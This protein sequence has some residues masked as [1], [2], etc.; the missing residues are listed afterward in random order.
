ML[1]IIILLIIYIIAY[2]FIT[3]LDKKEKFTELE[4]IVDVYVVTLKNPERL[5]NIALQEKKFNIPIKIIDALYGPNIDTNE[6]LKNG[7]LLPEFNNDKIS[8]KKEIGC[9][10]S[11]KIIYDLISKNKTKKYTL[12]LEDDFNV[13]NDNFREVF[14]NILK[15]INDLDFDIIFLGNTFD[16]IGTQYKENIY[17]IDKNKKTI[18]TFAYIINNKNI[19]KIINLTKLIN[20]PIDIKLNNLIVSGLLNAYVINP[21]IINYKDSITSE[22]LS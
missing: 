22:I 1:N 20:E 14:E 9:Y 5:L 11:H 6:L 16:N 7:D 8:R 12:V 2:I 13:M 3:T 21:N 10:Q 4:E 15:N 17:Y 18:G 19:D